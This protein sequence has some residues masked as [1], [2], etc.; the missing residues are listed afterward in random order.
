MAHTLPPHADK[1]E[2]QRASL[3]LC[4]YVRKEHTVCNEQGRVVNN[5]LAGKCVL[6][7]KK[8]SELFWDEVS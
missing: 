1:P 2:L 7:T 3:N 8:A 4:N 6:S 5:K